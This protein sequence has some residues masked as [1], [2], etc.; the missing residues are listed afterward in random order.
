MKATALFC[1][2]AAGAALFPSVAMADDPRDP[3]LSR[4]AEARARDKAIIRRL[5][6][7]ELAHVRE[8]D[9]R[10][11]EGWQAYREQGGRNEDY[12]A[13]R[14]DYDRAQADYARQRAAYERQ[15]AA[16]RHAVQMCESGHYEYCDG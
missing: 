14:S 4:S 5:N 9:A 3:L 15:R 16:W 7:D 12:A 1:A 2:L 13:R 6:Q 10:Y 11:A 8:R